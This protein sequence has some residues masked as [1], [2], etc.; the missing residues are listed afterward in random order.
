M[1]GTWAPSE[2]FAKVRSALWWELCLPPV[3][4]E[5]FGLGRSPDREASYFWRAVPATEKAD[6]RE[7]VAHWPQLRRQEEEDRANFDAVVRECCDAL[8]EPM[9]FRPFA[10]H[11]AWLP[12]MERDYLF[13]SEVERETLHHMFPEQNEWLEK[14]FYERSDGVLVVRGTQ[15]TPFPGGEG[16][17]PLH[18]YA[19]LF[20]QRPCF[21]ALRRS[22]FCSTREAAQANSGELYARVD[23]LGDALPEGGALRHTAETLAAQVMMDDAVE[24]G[25]PMDFMAYAWPAFVRAIEEEGYYF[26]CDEL[27]LVA[28]RAAVNIVLAKKDSEEAGGGE[29]RVEGYEAGHNGATAVVSLCSQGSQRVRSHFERLVPETLVADA[30]RRRDLQFADAQRRLQ[31]ER[32]AALYH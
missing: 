16:E 8:L 22:F 7:H 9:L 23:A 27:L 11:R 32:E 3:L 18:K 31:E 10:V 12:D 15:S 5:L 17:A 28:D 24:I 19:A 25:E 2:A 6:I 26:S 21:D 20:D 13:L 1:N 14:P 30:Q 29:Y 4:W